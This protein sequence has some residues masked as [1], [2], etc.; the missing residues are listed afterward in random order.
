MNTSR[1][2]STKTKWRNRQAYCLKN[3]SVELTM[4]TGG[5]H[6]S[7]FRLVDPHSSVNALWEVPWATLEPNQFGKSL[8]KNVRKYGP[9]PVGRFLA[10]FTG[11]V[12][13][14]DYFGGPSEAEAAQGLALHGEAANSRWRL[15]ESRQSATEARLSL[16]A[17]LPAAGLRFE[18]DLRLRRDESVVYVEERLT[19]ERSLDHFFHW[20]QHITLGAPLLHPDESSVALSGNRAIMQPRSL[21][22]NTIR[23]PGEASRL[24]W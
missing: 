13:C 12:V 7:D 6:I 5:G 3:A 16:G 22:Y 8:R 4:L 11:H 9:P 17:R 20:T 24:V 14:V 2:S 19:N 10:S 23:W 18:R 15:L 21:A 1:P